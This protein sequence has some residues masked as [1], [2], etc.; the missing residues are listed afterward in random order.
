MTTDNEL[1]DLTLDEKWERLEAD[2]AAWT[3]RE[4][5][6]DA[7]SKA[8]DERYGDL[9]KPP[10]ASK[11]FAALLWEQNKHAS[12]GKALQLVSRVLEKESRLPGIGGFIGRLFGF[13]RRPGTYRASDA[14]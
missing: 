9:R 14:A 1:M 10:E 2:V 12:E 13:G 11:E 6:L 7:R 8:F 4:K 3:E 5:A